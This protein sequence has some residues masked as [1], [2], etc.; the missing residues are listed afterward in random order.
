MRAP[1]WRREIDQARASADDA[2]QAQRDA[3][4]FSAVAHQ[5]NKRAQKVGKQLRNELMANGFA[6]A[7]RAAFGSPGP[8][9]E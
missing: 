9:H 6:D 7:L 1:W 2:E 4:A 3:E 5:A 8:A